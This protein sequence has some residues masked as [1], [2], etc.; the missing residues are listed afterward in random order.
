MPDTYYYGEKCWK[1][2]R[3]GYGDQ[4]YSCWAR[5]VAVGVEYASGLWT[6]PKVEG[7]RLFVFGTAGNAVRFMRD[8]CPLDERWEVWQCEAIN[9]RVQDRVIGVMSRHDSPDF[10]KPF[11]HDDVSLGKKPPWK[12]IFEYGATIGDVGIMSCEALRLDRLY[13]TMSD[14]YL[15]GPAF[16][17]G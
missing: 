8:T 13:A 11:W 7:S 15:L 3:V 9:P 12:N 6:Y 14:G 10:V 16:E 1:V 5:H 4:R 2:V 17:E